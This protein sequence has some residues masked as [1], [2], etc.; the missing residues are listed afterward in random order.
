MSQIEETTTEAPVETERDLLARLERMVESGA[1]TLT[2]DRTKLSSLDFPLASEVDGNIWVYAMAAVSA[3]LWW[4]VGMWYGI[5]AGVT[6]L[7]LYQ[8][9]G[10]RYIAPPARP[11]HPRARPQGDGY[12]AGA[13][14]LRRR[15]PDPRRWRPA[16]P[17]PARQ[18]VRPGARRGE[19][20]GVE[21]SFS[22]TAGEAIR[23]R[24]R[25]LQWGGRPRPPAGA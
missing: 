10:K 21:T 20:I 1:L 9:L 4:R 22:C 14:A 19:E 23:R 17:G 8:T 16:L 15:D 18:L 3:A 24:L 2:V 6:S 5:A 13:V 11:A 7:I 25:S 12:L